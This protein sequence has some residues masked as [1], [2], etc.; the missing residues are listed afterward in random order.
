MKTSGGNSFEK[1]SLKMLEIKSN[2]MS[3]WLFWDSFRWWIDCGTVIFAEISGIRGKFVENRWTWMCFSDHNLEMFI[4][5]VPKETLSLVRLVKTGNHPH[6]QSEK[7]VI[8]STLLTSISRI[9]NLWIWGILAL[10]K[11]GYLYLS[12]TQL[13]ASCLW[14]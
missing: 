11:H 1:F 8:R 12:L 3:E 6:S 2:V 5:L 14:Y 4:R 10:N 7:V 9:N 13:D